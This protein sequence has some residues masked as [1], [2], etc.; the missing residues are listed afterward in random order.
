MGRTCIAFGGEEKCIQSSGG[1]SSMTGTIQ[2]KQIQVFCD[3]EWPKGIKRK[4]GL[5]RIC[6]PVCVVLDGILLPQLACHTC[7]FSLLHK[8][9]K[10]EISRAS[11]RDVTLQC[12]VFYW[13]RDWPTNGFNKNQQKVFKHI[14][15]NWPSF[16]LQNKTCAPV[17]GRCYCCQKS[18]FITNSKTRLN[19]QKHITCQ[20]HSNFLRFL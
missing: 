3:L 10:T 16:V 19:P 6:F 2:M 13:V 18:I 15:V 11:L 9:Q 1:E 12:C 4:S 5:V 7:F 17:Y 8:K 14:C 20:P